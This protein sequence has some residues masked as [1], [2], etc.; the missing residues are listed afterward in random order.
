MLING[1]RFGDEFG[2]NII[3]E[4][5]ETRFNAG[6]WITKQIPDG[7][8]IIG[9]QCTIRNNMT[10]TRLDFLLW[11]PLNPVKPNDLFL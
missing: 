2:R 11:K 10:I 6:T 5:W 9:L 8:E 3:Q 7:E 1:V 4:E